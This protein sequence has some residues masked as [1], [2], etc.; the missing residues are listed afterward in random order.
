VKGNPFASLQFDNL[1]QIAKNINSKFGNDS[2]ESKY[3]MSNLIEE[4]QKSFDTFVEENP[5][6]LLPTVLDFDRDM[7]IVPINGSELSNSNGTP[8]ESMKDSETSP[9]WTEGVRKGETRS[10]SNKIN[11]NNIDTFWI[12][13][14]L[15]KT[16]RIKCLSHFIRNCNLDFVGLQKL[17]N[18]RCLI[19]P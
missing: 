13:M 14:G 16:G 5:E 1:N 7:M 18:L 19:V 2:E 10:R 8:E 15:N 11:Q 9:P 6:V 12:I 3:I 4:E 17:R